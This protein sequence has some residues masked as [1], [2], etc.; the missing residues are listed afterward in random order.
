MAP[1][2]PP[3]PSPSDEAPKKKRRTLRDAETELEACRS[4]LQEAKRKL[5]LTARENA[6]MKVLLMKYIEK[7]DSLLCSSQLSVA[8]S[9]S[10][11]TTV[12]LQASSPGPNSPPV[13]DTD[14]SALSQSPHEYTTAEEGES[15][16]SLWNSDFQPCGDGFTEPISQLSQISQA[17]HWSELSS[18]SNLDAII[19][20]LE[21]QDTSET[22]RMGT[23]QAEYA[24]LK[25]QKT[26]VRVGVGVMLMS[27]KHPGC[28][29]IGQRKGSH[30]EGKFA[31]P[32]GHLEMYET[33]EECAL[34]EIKEETDLEL[35][36][37]KFTTATNDPMEDEG[38]HYITILMQAVVDDE[39]TVKNMEPNK[40]EGWSWVPWSD[41][42]S[43]DDMF[44]PLLH[45]AH[46]EFTPTFVYE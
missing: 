30:G 32:G 19:N 31:L 36:E 10:Q 41:L 4:A 40:C 14:T 26:V 39:Q 43:R 22:N 1:L 35:K 33:W 37:A 6:K 38:K 28:V 8:E 21:T 29:L 12:V 18:T 13:A 2:P 46:S 44:T 3:A 5:V 7:D 9:S 34:R 15:E 27:K 17:S 24:K 42:R 20:F 23:L 45:V 11:P 16:D 25:E